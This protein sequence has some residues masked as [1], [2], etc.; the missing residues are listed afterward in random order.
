M[1]TIGLAGAKWLTNQTAGGVQKLMGGG[2]LG[3]GLYR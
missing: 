1:Y 2:F 3:K